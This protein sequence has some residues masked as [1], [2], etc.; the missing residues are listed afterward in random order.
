MSKIQYGDAIYAVQND[1]DGGEP[2]IYSDPMPVTGVNGG[3]NGNVVSVRESDGRTRWFMDRDCFHS[4]QDAQ[5][6]Y[7]RRVKDN[8]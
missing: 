3:V 5:D 6:E 4:L 8:G 7:E 2:I 1:Y